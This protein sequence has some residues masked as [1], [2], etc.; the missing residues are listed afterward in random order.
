MACLVTN[1]E[2]TRLITHMLSHFCSFA[3]VDDLLKQANTLAVIPLSTSCEP[4]TQG[5]IYAGI[6]FAYLE[7]ATQANEVWC[8]AKNHTVT[9]GENQHCQWSKSDDIICVAH[10]LNK[11]DCAHI[12]QATFDAYINIFSVLE[13]QRYP[14]MFRAWNYLPNINQGQG[15]N[16]VY[17]RFCTGRL[18]AF[19]HLGIPSS[20]FPAASALGHHGQG[21]VI[22]V[23]ASRITPVHFNN[24]RQVNAYEYPRQYG[25]SSPSFARATTLSHGSA[26]PLFISGTASIIGH[27]TLHADDVLAQLQVT[28]Q[29]IEHLISTTKAHYRQETQ[30]TAP[31]K[32]QH[33]DITLSTF[34]VYVRHHEHLES[35]QRWL[36]KHYPHVHCIFTFADICR[37]ELLVEIE[38]YCE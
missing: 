11:Q 20:D 27:Q 8:V 9:R 29:N 3:P 6:P 2:F 23:F 24:Q 35:I 5:L 21:A 36:K 26:R 18:R 16:E 28:T 34:K 7:S 12:E 30:D 13:Q 15:D 14:L 4:H 32:D 10:W 25:I 1:H 22:Y 37:A 19:E 17:K 38:A 33:V 31:H